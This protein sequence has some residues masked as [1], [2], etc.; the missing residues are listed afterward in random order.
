MIVHMQLSD[1]EKTPE[2]QEFGLRL[3]VDCSERCHIN[4]CVYTVYIYITSNI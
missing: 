2:K 3:L 1:T 4:I